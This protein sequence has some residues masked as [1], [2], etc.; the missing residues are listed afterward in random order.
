M[1][2]ITLIIES[3][4]D[5]GRPWTFYE[6]VINNSN[7]SEEEKNDFSKIYNEAAKFELWN[8]SDL[9]L[10]CENSKTFLKANTN[11]SEKAIMQIVNAIAY[12]WR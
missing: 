6:Y 3:F 9:T 12:E 7:V 11:F 8:F 5:L 10:G 2:N 1:K 4:T